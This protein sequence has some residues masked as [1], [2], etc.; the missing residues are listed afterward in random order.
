M[1][2][3][4]ST[5]GISVYETSEIKKLQRSCYFDLAYQFPFNVID[6]RFEDLNITSN[7]CFARSVL[8]QGLL[9]SKN[10]FG[11]CFSICCARMLLGF[12]AFSNMFGLA[13][14]ILFDG[15]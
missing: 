9:A 12:P 6:R 7:K 11:F 10:S 4:V 3:P 1:E 8:L 5:L 14:N 13:Y 2:N 15:N